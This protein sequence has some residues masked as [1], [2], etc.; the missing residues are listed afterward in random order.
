MEPRSAPSRNPHPL[1]SPNSFS[2]PS[3]QLLSVVARAFALNPP[4]VRLV[5]SVVGR[6]SVVRRFALLSIALL[7]RRE[8][9]V[10]EARTGREIPGSALG[11]EPIAR[12]QKSVY[13]NIENSIL[14]T[15]HVLAFSLL[16][17]SQA[18]SSVDEQDF[19][20]E[21]RNGRARRFLYL[22]ILSA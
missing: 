11:I 17:R 18:Q 4:C 1:S 20:L 3:W 9:E 13:W 10:F 2:T 8:L 21:C 22:P 6:R 14:N 15:P 16:S 19:Y 5:S 12:G 7:P